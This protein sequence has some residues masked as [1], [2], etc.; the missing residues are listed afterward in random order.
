MESAER[1]TNSA[2]VI[3]KAASSVQQ[4]SEARMAQSD[5]FVQLRAE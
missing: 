1:W 3:D 4:V 2:S 5:W